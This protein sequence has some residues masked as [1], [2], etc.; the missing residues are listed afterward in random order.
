MISVRIDKLTDKVDSL[1]GCVIVTAKRAR[2]INNYYHHIGEGTFDVYPP[3][4]VDIQSKNY[5][6][7]AQQEIIED[8]LKFHYRD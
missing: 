2:Q 4:M 8:K 3:P 7:I 6:S 5:L 1:Y